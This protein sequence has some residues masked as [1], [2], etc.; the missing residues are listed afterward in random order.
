[1]PASIGSRFR[2]LRQ[3]PRQAGGVV[4][5]HNYCRRLLLLLLLLLLLSQRW[6]CTGAPEAGGGLP[7]QLAG[8]GDVGPG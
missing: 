3:G 4:G 2:K 6:V 7:V 5:A 1:M 8:P